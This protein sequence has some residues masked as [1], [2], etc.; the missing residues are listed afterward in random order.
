MQSLGSQVTQLQQQ[1]QLLPSIKNDKQLVVVKPRYTSLQIAKKH[2]IF[3]EGKKLTVQHLAD[4]GFCQPRAAADKNIRRYYTLT[5]NDISG[6]LLLTVG[7]N[8][9]LS[10]I[11]GV[12]SR[13][14]RDEVLAWWDTSSGGIPC[15][16]VKCHVSGEQFWPLPT[17]FRDLVFLLDMPLAMDCILRGDYNYV[18]QIPSLLSARIEVHLQSHEDKYNRSLFWGH[19]GYPDTWKAPPMPLADLIRFLKKMDAARFILKLIVYL[20]TRD[21]QTVK[22]AFDSVVKE[23]Q[24]YLIIIAQK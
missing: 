23:I 11:S 3:I 9:N 15:L 4:L 24:N 18:S 6:N 14:L 1:Q 19:F 13:M 17:R 22:E 2:T 12:W 7:N 5:H 10:Q 16:H 8:F 20:Q 21:K